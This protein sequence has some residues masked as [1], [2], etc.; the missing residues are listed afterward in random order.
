[1]TRWRTDKPIPQI[2]SLRALEPI[3]A[4]GMF[5]LD[6]P[7]RVAAGV[8]RS[9]YLNKLRKWAAKQPAK[10][11]IAQPAIDSDD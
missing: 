8:A 9:L 4:V 3:A 11:P 5:G 7:A 10:S 2:P 1:V 6:G